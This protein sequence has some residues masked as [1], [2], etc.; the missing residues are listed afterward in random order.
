MNTEQLRTFLSLAETKNFSA[1]AKNLILAQSTVSKRIS[2]LEKEVGQTLFTRDRSVTTLTAAG[3]ALLEYA[4]QIVNMEQSALAQVN[5]S[6]QYAGYLVLG[7][8]YAYFDIYLSGLLHS[9][10]EKHP[11]IS[12]KVKFGHTGQILAETKRAQVDI[13]FTHHPFHHPDYESLLLEE[14]DVILIT[15]RQ[16]TLYQKGI[17]YKDIRNLPFISSN[18]LYE[19]TKNWLF[20]RSQQFQLE[21][22]IAATAFR[23]LEGSGWYTLLPRKMVE[24]QLLSGKLLEIPILDAAI[25]KVQYYMT[26]RRQNAQ[27]TGVK[28]WLEHTHIL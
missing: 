10:L 23:F 3:K 15:D 2:E 28:A 7:T 22:D 5:R 19:T 16:N 14:D 26:Y 21:M 17:S 27:Q 20:P 24:D 6:S 8:A 13:G 4:E 9:F 18:F 1:S 25:P 11:E 12:V